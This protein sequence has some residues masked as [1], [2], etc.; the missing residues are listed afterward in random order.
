M[1]A[2]GEP[3][4]S[5]SRRKRSPQTPGESR[6]YPGMIMSVSSPPNS[7]F[8]SAAS[9]PVATQRPVVTTLHG[10]TRTDEYAW[11]R[12]KEN[13][14]VLDHLRAENAYTNAMLEHL[15]PLREE[16]FLEFKTR[17]LETDL[18]VP[19]SKGPWD[20]FG[21]TI[22]G[23]QYGI[24]CRRPRGA[25]PNEATDQILLDENVL[26]D[27]HEYFALGTFEVSPDHSLLAYAF[28]TDGD[29]IYEL[30]VRNL[31][32]LEDLT[33]ELTET[34]PGVVW[35][36]DGTT[37]FYTTLDDMMRPWQV[38]RHV[39]GTEQQDDVLVYQE[40]DDRFFVGLSMSATDAYLLLSSASQVTTEIRVLSASTPNGEWQL[41]SPRRQDIEYGVDHHIARDGSQ[42][43]FVLTNDGAENFRL[44]VADTPGGEPRPVQSLDGT[45]VTEAG[46]KLDA[47]DL[48]RNHVALYERFEGLERIRI[49]T[50]DDAGNPSGQR[51]LTHRDPVHSVWGTSNVEFDSPTL[52]FG[53]TSMTTPGSTFDEDLVT[54]ERILK[55]QQPVLGGF[56]PEH[57]VSE[58]LWAVAD[59]GTRVPI[60]LVRHRNTPLDGTAPCVLYGY[61]SYEI[62][63]DPTFSVMRLSLLDRGMVFAIAHVR[64]GGE[65]GRR[66]YLDGK[67][68]KK[69]NT[70]TDF[71]ACAKLLIANNYVHPDKL[72]ARGGSAGGLLMGAVTNLEPSLWNAIVAEVPFVDSLT[73]M[74]DD[75]LPL[76]EIEKEEWGN[77]ND[78]EFYSFMKSYAPFENVAAVEYPA[79]L[80]TGG[81]ND[82]RVGYF[83]PAKW[84]QRIRSR[85]TG[86]GPIL[87]RTEMGAGHGG[88]SGRYDSWRDEAFTLAF[89][90][91]ATKRP[92]RRQT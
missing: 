66:W 1:D 20:Y 83:E 39:L 7:S 40:D 77:P 12:E 75:S 17:I 87:L 72:A 43:W 3:A 19:T 82:P 49:I 29:E 71:I 11:L 52:R 86:G 51:V 67:F 60:S 64:G 35:S 78:A 5:T 68:L 62:S 89:L 8:G 48:F 23:K 42:R 81:L 34:A 45:E 37:L 18:S 57:Y 58:R 55:K 74:L 36:A 38:W 26:A 50:L 90:I 44:A 10:D 30:H 54:G 73:T 25:E 24:H 56:D 59:D 27:G 88:P 4:R 2:P 22:E 32:S 76:T 92:R 85:T 47:F 65:L 79:M 70:F 53:Y 63:I 61:G 31:S 28:D 84:V 14:E 6:R 9:A 13:P 41:F 91:D 16:L 21:K 33:D 46:A 80:V 15:T 69:R